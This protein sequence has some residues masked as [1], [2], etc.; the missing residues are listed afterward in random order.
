MARNDMKGW[1]TSG[2]L[3]DLYF[4]LKTMTPEEREAK[5]F[6]LFVTGRGILNGR[7]ALEYLEDVLK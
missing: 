1:A 4:E 3:T 6:A 2:E 5:T 7:E